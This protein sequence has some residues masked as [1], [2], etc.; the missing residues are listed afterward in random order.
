MPRN[1]HALTL[2][3]I[4][5]GLN[6]ESNGTLKTFLMQLTLALAACELQLKPRRKANFVIATLYSHASARDILH[7]P[8]P[9]TRKAARKLLN[10]GRALCV[11]HLRNGTLSTHYEIAVRYVV[12]TTCVGETPAPAHLAA[13]AFITASAFTVS[14]CG[15]AYII[16]NLPDMLNT[17]A[18]NYGNA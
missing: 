8:L 18:L 7:G 15:N 3:Q 9:L 4:A 2:E 1:K 11:T 16:E 13:A 6:D 12:S 10:N 17:L 14:G 5:Y